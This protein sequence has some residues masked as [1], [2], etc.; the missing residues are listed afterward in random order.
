MSEA[1]QV[2]LFEL[3]YRADDAKRRAQ[4]AGIGLF[5]VRALVEAAGGHAWAVNRPEGGSEFGFDLP[6]FVEA[7]DGPAIG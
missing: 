7:D 5:V 2:H 1:D 6:V 3:F 4:G